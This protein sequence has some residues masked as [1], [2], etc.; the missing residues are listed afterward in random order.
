MLW[1]ALWAVVKRSEDSYPFGCSS[2]CF[3]WQPLEDGVRWTRHYHPSEANQDKQDLCGGWTTMTGWKEANEPFKMFAR[4]HAPYKVDNTH[5]QW[6]REANVQ[7]M[8]SR[9]SWSDIGTSGQYWMSEHIRHPHWRVDTRSHG[10]M[11]AMCEDKWPGKWP[12]SVAP[13]LG[14]D[15]MRMS[16]AHV[17]YKLGPKL[18]AYHSN[19]HHNQPVLALRAPNID[20]ETILEPYQHRESMRDTSKTPSNVP[21]RFSVNHKYIIQVCGAFLGLEGYS[22]GEMARLGHIIGPCV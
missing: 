21:L 19:S 22:V 17:H 15:M 11:V 4:V 5:W 2:L 6:P 12:E 20:Q 9:A 3:M 7:G 18:G 16:K 10:V 13:L 14:D 8:R 1:V